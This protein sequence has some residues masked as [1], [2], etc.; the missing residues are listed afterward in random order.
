MYSTYSTGKSYRWAGQH[1]F[2]TGAV[3]LVPSVW[4]HLTNFSFKYILS[5]FSLF[6]L[7]IIPGSVEDPD[8]VGSGLFAGS[9][10]VQEIL[11]GSGSDPT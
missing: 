8:L 3:P 10:S 4:W 11:A 1:S 2:I 6:Y 9:D 5:Y 7:S